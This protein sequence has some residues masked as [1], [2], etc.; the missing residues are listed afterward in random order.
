M[1]SKFI[2]RLT[3]I[4]SKSKS[5]SENKNRLSSKFGL[6]AQSVNQLRFNFLS[7]FDNPNNF[8]NRS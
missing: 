5:N 3:T 6:I 8:F 7:I 4:I 1:N 2:I